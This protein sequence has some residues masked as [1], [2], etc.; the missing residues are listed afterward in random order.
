MTREVAAGPPMVGISGYSHV[1]I[2]VDDIGAARHFYCDLL[3]FSELD[4]PDFGFPGAW[5]RV[6]DLQLHLSEIEKMPERTSGFPHFALYV[7][8]E[9]F[10]ETM[11]ALR[12]SGVR[13]LGQPSSRVDFGRVTVLAAFVVDPA[14]N[15]IELTD[16]GPL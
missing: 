7:P 11:Q 6:G 1:A 10:D 9:E 4:R 14:G 16:V 12:D 13:F 15:T 2:D 3:G 8:T 5:L